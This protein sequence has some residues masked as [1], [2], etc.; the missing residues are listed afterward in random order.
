MISASKSLTCFDRLVDRSTERLSIVDIASVISLMKDRSIL[1]NINSSILIALISI[2][3]ESD[4]TES[5]LS[6][7]LYSLVQS[8]SP[9]LSILAEIFALA[10]FT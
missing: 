6:S 5:W 1:E 3:L 9:T 4:A 8:S 7:V 2:L 10:T